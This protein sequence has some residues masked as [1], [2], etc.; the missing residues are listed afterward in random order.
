[1]GFLFC[2]TKDLLASKESHHL[3]H[4]DGPVD[5]ESGVEEDVKLSTELDIL[6]G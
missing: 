3:H 4:V 5:E 6:T 2:T 1:M